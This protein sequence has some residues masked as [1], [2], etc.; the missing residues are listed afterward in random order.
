MRRDFE[1]YRN[2]CFSSI[3]KSEWSVADRRLMS[4][5]VGLECRGKFIHPL[6][7]SL[8]Q[9]FLHNGLYD[10]VHSFNLSIC[11]RVSNCRNSLFNTMLTTEVFE[12]STIELS[13]II[14][15]NGSRKAK[16]TDDVSDNEVDYFLHHDR[17]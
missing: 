2:D 10:F 5:P 1:F 14:I 12:F 4:G 16:I 15:Y 8:F 13:P 17:G 7:Y 11:F 9:M 6:A 3:S